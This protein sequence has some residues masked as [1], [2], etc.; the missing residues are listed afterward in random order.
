MITLVT[1]Q[2]GDG[3]DQR[4][5]CGQMI[6]TLSFKAEMISKV[7]HGHEYMTLTHGLCLH[8]GPALSGSPFT[9]GDL[10]WVSK[11]LPAHRDGH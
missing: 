4:T 1:T 10:P 7:S 5:P 8:R 2:R 9:S 3:T 11:H 6:R